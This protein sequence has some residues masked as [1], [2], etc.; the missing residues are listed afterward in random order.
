[1]LITVHGVIGSEKAAFFSDPR[2]A[3]I[4]A[5]NGIRVQ[6]DT[7]GSRQIATSIDLGHYDFAF[8]SSEPAAE[9]ILRARHL[10][11]RYTPFS[12][13]MAIATFAPIADLL[14][15]AGVVHPG[16]VTTFDMNRYLDLTQHGVQWNQLDGN[17]V[18]PINKSL[19]IGTTDPRTSNSAAMYLAVA[20]YVANDNTMVRGQTAEDFVLSKV[21]RLFTKQGYMDNSSAGPFNEYLSAGMGPQPMVWIYEAQFVEAAASGRIRPDMVLMYPSPTVL[22]QHTVVPLTPAGDRLGRLLTEDPQLQRLAAEHGFRPNDPAQF[23]LVAADHHVPIE[24]N[25]MNVVDTPSYDTL[26]YLLDGIAR[27]YH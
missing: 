9:R 12:S 13:P 22:S 4:L 1:V 21:S 27:S 6:A 14:T 19:L 26:E 7:A 24:G 15:R 17:T 25:L 2:V 11:A 8:P 10:S 16:P 3:D 18:Y 20:G 5:H 23:T